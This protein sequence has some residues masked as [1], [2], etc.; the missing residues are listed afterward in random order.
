MAVSTRTATAVHAMTFLA[1]WTDE[2]LQSSATMA[3]SLESNPVLVR[4]VLGA[5]RDAGLVYA[6]EGSGGGW[7]LT[8]PAE[9]ISLLDAYAA[10]EDSRALLPTHAHP[11]N[12][13]CVIGRHAQSVLEAEFSAAQ[14][15]LD[16]RLAQT[17]IADVL[18][19]ILGRERT[20][21]SSS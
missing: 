10:V 11:P 8:R 1:Y 17:T 20:W 9:E 5:L 7:Q 3:D 4:R 16:E 2:G 21:T 12:Q 19:R 18:E 6:L 13:N 15:A 14:R